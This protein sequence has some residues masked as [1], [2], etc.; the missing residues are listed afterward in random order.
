[1]FGNDSTIPID[2]HKFDL[3]RTISTG[4]LTPHLIDISKQ[5]L[6]AKSMKPIF[7]VTSYALDGCPLSNASFN[8]ATDFDV[9]VS[10][11]LFFCMKYLT[12]SSVIIGL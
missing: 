6:R 5:G 10:S 11:E 7:P 3:G 9:S 8:P 1:M 12:S 4:G 2:T